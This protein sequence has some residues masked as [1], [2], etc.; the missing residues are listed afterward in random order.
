MS[1]STQATRSTEGTQAPK[2][3]K[4]PEAPRASGHMGAPA[5]RA[6]GTRDADGVLRALAV[7]AE[8][9]DEHG[10]LLV[11]DWLVAEDEPD[12]ADAL[13]Q[14]CQQR[15]RDAGVSRLAWM[16]P[17]WSPWFAWL[18][19]RGAVAGPSRHLLL[20]RTDLSRYDA[21]WLRDHWW[22]QPLDWANNG[23]TGT[24][25]TTGVAAR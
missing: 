18:Q 10:S 17:A 19:D 5:V 4:A 14:A 3:S 11:W 6:I 2:D 21:F 9:A 23:W 8:H 13:L 16:L 1:T 20:G 24:G 22:A 12:A 7:L 15:A 25:A